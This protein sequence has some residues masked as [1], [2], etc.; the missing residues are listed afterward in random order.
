MVKEEQKM[1]L[2]KALEL[3]KKHFNE[4]MIVRKKKGND[5]ANMEDCLLN[6]KVRAKILG[7]LNVD[8]STPYGVAINDV[9]LKLQRTCNL[10]F[11]K[12]KTA[13]NETLYD[14][15]TID[16]PNY[17]DLLKE[18]LVDNGIMEG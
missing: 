4:R 17:V 1:K 11:P 10:L 16:L 3:E 8:I 9:V 18:I 5:Y 7:L 12:P 2:S 13:K 6:F 14:T 15:V